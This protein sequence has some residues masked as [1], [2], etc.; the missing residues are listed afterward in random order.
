MPPLGELFRKAAISRFASTLATLLESGLPV[1]EALSITERIM[2]NVVLAEVVAK[3]RAR[4]MEG[5]E[6]A[7]TDIAIT[8]QAR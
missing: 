7:L 3:V 2:G 6:M 4:V 8:L 1:M 5:A